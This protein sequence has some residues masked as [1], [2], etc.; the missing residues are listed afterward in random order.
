MHISIYNV[1]LYYIYTVIYMY[2]SIT[3]INITSS[4]Y[5]FIFDIKLHSKLQHKSMDILPSRSM[6]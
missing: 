4:N 5:L 2:I 3:I 6:V 1:Y